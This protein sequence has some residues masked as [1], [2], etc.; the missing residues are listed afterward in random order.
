LKIARKKKSFSLKKVESETKIKKEF[1]EAIEK[2]AWSNLPDFS[3]TSGF[4][5]NLASFLGLNTKTAL[6]LLKRDYPP[7]KVHV[8]PKPDVENKFVWTPKYTFLVG[9]LLVIFAI[10]GYLGFQF[11]KF[12]SAPTLE[13]NQPKEGLVVNSTQVVISGKTDPN[14]T[15]K[16]NNELILIEDDGR[17]Q[18]KV[19]IFSGTK[20]IVIEAVSR[21]GKSSIVRRNIKPELN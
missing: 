9:I 15:L 12:N 20:E 5:K 2:N 19:E 4:I 1:I 17:F 11:F 18:T 8:N 16:I 6:A 10:F 21:S 3:V 13:V 7:R 14:A